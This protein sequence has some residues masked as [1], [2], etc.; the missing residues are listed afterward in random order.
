MQLVDEDVL[1]PTAGA[2]SLFQPRTTVL[3]EL[4]TEFD[5]QSTAAVYHDSIIKSTFE[6]LTWF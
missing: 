3:V 2:K 6:L 5:D 1:S 4:S